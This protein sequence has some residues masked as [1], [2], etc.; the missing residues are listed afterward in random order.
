MMQKFQEFIRKYR[1]HG[2]IF[3]IA[4]LIWFHAITER[5]YEQPIKVW[6]E[7]V[8]VPQGYVIINDYPRIRRVVFRGKGKNLIALMNA[9]IRILADLNQSEQPR[10]VVQ[11]SLDKIRLPTSLVQLEAVKFLDPDTVQYFLEPVVSKEVPVKARIRIVPGKGYVLVGSVQVEPQRVL[12]RGPIRAIDEI[13]TVLTRPL[14]LKDVREGVTGR[15][16]LVNV[17][18]GKVLLEPPAVHYR[19]RVEKLAE[20]TLEGIRVKVINA[21]GDR[22]VSVRPPTLSLTIR[23]G[24]TYIASLT[25]KDIVAYVDYRRFLLTGKRRLPA[26]IELPEYVTFDNVRPETFEIQVR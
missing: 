22:Q 17:H 26:I 24:E 23:G 10:Q 14:E 16:E 20:K 12:V 15:V 8:N 2:I 13:D 21:P 5:Y 9:R 11:L 4:V 25:A 6:V 19:A 7:P 3:I 1:V 18:P